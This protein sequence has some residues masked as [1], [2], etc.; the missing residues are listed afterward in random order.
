MKSLFSILALLVF[1]FTAT[2]AQWEEPKNSWGIRVI[3]K[4]VKSGDNLIALGDYVY[5]SSDNGESWVCNDE[6]RGYI[7]EKRGNDVFTLDGVNRFFH[8]TDNG[9]SWSKFI[10]HGLYKAPY[11][12]SLV[13]GNNNKLFL[14]STGNG[15]Y[16]SSDDCRNWVE[17]DN[18]LTGK[19]YSLALA[20]NNLFAATPSGIFLSTD[21]GDNWIEKNN[22]IVTSHPQYITSD[23]NNV[24][25]CAGREQGIYLSTNNGDSWT[26]KNNGLNLEDVHFLAISGNNLFASSTFAGEGV[27]RSTDYGESWTKKSNGLENVAVYTITIIGNNIYAGTVGGVYLSTDNGDS[28]IEKNNGILHKKYLK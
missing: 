18:G 15:V 16:L 5:L 26:A 8:S 14:G 6:V 10:A 21:D 4:I 1:T 19:I 28:W 2:F 25:V 11:K 7:M 13:V 3:Q 23:G 27:Y 17:K 12:T 24:F 22:G 20:G 9:V